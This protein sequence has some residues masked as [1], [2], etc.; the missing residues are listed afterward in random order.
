MKVILAAGGPDSAEPLARVLANA[1][2]T[3]AVLPEPTPSAP[4]LR[5]ADLLI[6][7]RNSAAALE[8]AGPKKRILLAPREG[9]VD[10]NAVS[11]GFDDVIPMPSTDDEIVARVRH[12]L[13]SR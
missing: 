9:T 7:D 3:V 2:F 8:G 5:G 4:E 11:A 12:V 10:L 1:G 13:G 6:A